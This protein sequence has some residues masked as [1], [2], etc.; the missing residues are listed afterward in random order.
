MGDTQ[1][2]RMCLGNVPATSVAKAWVSANDTFAMISS[3]TGMPRI[4]Y[5]TV[6][7]CGVGSWNFGCFAAAAFTAA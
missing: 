7:P 3:G 1:R 4:R 2:F 5:E 6:T